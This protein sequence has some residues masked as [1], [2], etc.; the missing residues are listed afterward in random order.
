MSD[1]YGVPRRR[2]VGEAWFWIVM[3]VVA[4]LAIG[5]LTFAIR[6]VTAGPKG[7]LQ[8]REQIQSGNSRIAAY[9]HFF[10]L[11]AA[12]QTDEATIK[13]Q[14]DELATGPSESRRGQIHANIAALTA[15]RAEKINQYNADARKDYTIGQFRSSGLPY[16]LGDSKETSCES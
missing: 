2:L 7:Q 14:Q 8:A 9:N 12:V 4:A 5:A 13:A 3:V 10:D 16:T 1:M 15:A 11:C 6:W